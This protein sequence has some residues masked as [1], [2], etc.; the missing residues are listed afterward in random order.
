MTTCP[1]TFVPLVHCIINDTVSEAMPDLRQMLLEFT[2][3]MNL[4]SLI[5]A[6][7]S[8]IYPIPRLGVTPGGRKLYH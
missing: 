7:Y 1:E 2:D 4:M 5:A 3:V 8:F 6:Y